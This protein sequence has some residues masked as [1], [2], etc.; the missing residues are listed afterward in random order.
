MQSG[1]DVYRCDRLRI[2]GIRTRNTTSVSKQARLMP[3]VQRKILIIILI[4]SS[5][6]WA[7][8]R[9]LYHKGG[10]G[11]FFTRGSDGEISM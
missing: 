2:L 6:R 8:S 1:S 11:Q 3:D 9:G 7:L 10:G 5:Y 4:I